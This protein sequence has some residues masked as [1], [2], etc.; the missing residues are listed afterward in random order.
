MMDELKK[1][2]ELLRL[3]EGAPREEVEK[4][5]F[6]SIRRERA[7]RLRQRSE[8]TGGQPVNFEEINKAYNTILAYDGQKIMAQFNPAVYGKYN[9]NYKFPMIGAIFF[10]VVMI[11]VIIYGIKGFIDHRHH[12]AM[13][14]KLPPVDLSI[15]FFGEFMN[16]DGTYSTKNLDFPVMGESYQV[17]IPDVSDLKPLEAELL[18]Q[19]PQ[20]KA[21]QAFYAYAPSEVKTGLDEILLESSMGMI[22]HQS[23]IY[24]MDKA[25]FAR[26]AGYYAL[27]P[28]EGAD[29]AKLGPGLKPGLLLKAKT[30]DGLEEHVYGVDISAS[31]LLKGFPLVGKS[32]IAGIGVNSD[33]QEHAFTFITRYL[34]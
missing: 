27:L 16:R 20:W 23:D 15:S 26:L 31:P 32:Y 17:K 24:I 22:D 30:E 2:Y 6:L 13:L 19:F 18:S 29:A 33:R 11:F 14:A 3:P 25:S 9:K 34:K 8:Q 12:T 4:R 7:I 21:V 5:Y 1:A 28:L 10:S